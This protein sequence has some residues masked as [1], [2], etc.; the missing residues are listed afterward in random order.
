ML[1]LILVPSFILSIPIVLGIYFAKRSLRLHNDQLGTN[2]MFT[3]EQNF[4]MLQGFAQL[5]EEWKNKPEQ[6]A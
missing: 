5:R 2:K 4:I 1:I 3:P 6:Q